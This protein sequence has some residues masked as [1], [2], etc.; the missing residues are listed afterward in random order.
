MLSRTAIGY[1]LHGRKYIYYGDRC[2]EVG[3]GD[4]FLYDAG[5]HY[6]ENIVGTRGSFEQILFY[7]SPDALQQIL[8]GLSTNYGV[9]Y[10]ARHACERCRT[11]NFVS[12]TATAPL[13]DFFGSVNQSF[14]Q[15]RFRHNDICQRI[16]L[17]ELIYLIIAEDECCLRSKLLSNADSANGHFANVIY[18]NIFNDVCIESL[19]QMTHRSLTS[20]KKEF[21]R[22]FSAPPHRW[23]IDQRLNRSKILLISTSKTISEVGAECAFSNISHF[24]KLFKNKFHDTPAVYRQKYQASYRR[25]DSVV[26][27]TAAHDGPPAAGQLTAAAGE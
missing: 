1:V 3:E 6:E 23:F 22:Q 27:E 7:I 15:E 11:R 8:L 5:F 16:K 14:R 10:T 12:M 26:D 13:H 24:I 18:D 21:K 17:N 9:G 25:D 2:A 20:F 19:A 4:M